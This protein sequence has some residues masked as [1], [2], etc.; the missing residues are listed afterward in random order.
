MHHSVAW[1]LLK[2]GSSARTCGRV[3]NPVAAV[4]CGGCGMAN[5]DRSQGFGFIFTNVSE[6]L[7]KKEWSEEAIVQSK[8]INFNKDSLFVP[9]K[10]VTSTPDKTPTEQIRENLDRLQSLHHR[11]HVM[12]EELNHIQS[13]KKGSKGEE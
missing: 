6:L 7:S 4:F 2:V 8:A 10:P 11:L 1:M 3:W 12:L 13:K 9:E 5:R